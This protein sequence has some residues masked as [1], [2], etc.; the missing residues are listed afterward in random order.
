[1]SKMNQVQWL[2]N[3]PRWVASLG[4]PIVLHKKMVFFKPSNKFFIVQTCS[5]NMAGYWPSFLQE[6]RPW[7]SLNP[8]THQKKKEVGQ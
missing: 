4:L 5:V 3:Q 8:Q 1:M 2:P 7:L 6:C